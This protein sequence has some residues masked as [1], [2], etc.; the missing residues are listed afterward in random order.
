MPSYLILANWTDQGIRNVKDSP[1]RLGTFKQVIEAGGGRLIYFYMT[2]GEYDFALIVEVPDDVAASHVVLQLGSQG[3]IR[4]T[5]L[6][7]FTEDEYRGIISSLPV[8][9]P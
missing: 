9:L 2:M 3:N 1:G 8:P 6:K 7:A 4:T 5:T